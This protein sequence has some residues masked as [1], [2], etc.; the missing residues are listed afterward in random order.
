MR[1][2]IENIIL[3]GSFLLIILHLCA[4]VFNQG[5]PVEVYV[6]INS[7]CKRDLSSINA[8]HPSQSMHFLVTKI[9]AEMQSGPLTSATL[10]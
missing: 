2:I 4:Y 9:L 8:I 1:K 6:Y 10:G 7:G 3:E 5:S